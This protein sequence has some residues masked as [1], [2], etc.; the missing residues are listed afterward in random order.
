MK[1]VEQM[2]ISGINDTGI[3]IKAVSSDDLYI[4]A[5]IVKKVLRES[6]KL[7]IEI[8]QLV[9]NILTRANVDTAERADVNINLQIPKSKGTQFIN[10]SFPSLQVRM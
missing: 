6:V 2:R 5:E 4:F 10:Y 3:I 8:S 7:R 9:T 1:A